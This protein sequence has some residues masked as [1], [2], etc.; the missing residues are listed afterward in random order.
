LGIGQPKLWESQALT[1]ALIGKLE[2][3]N[4]QLLDENEPCPGICI[5]GHKSRQ[6]GFTT[7]SRLMTD[8]RLFFWPYTR[9]MGASV[10]EA[11]V[12]DQ[13]YSRDKT[14]YNHLP[15]FL[16]PTL[17]FDVK[18]KQISFETGSYVMYQQANQESGL[19]QGSQF[20]V[21]HLTEV[22]SWPHPNIIELDFIPTIPQSPYALCLLESTAQG[23]GDWW[24]EFT[25]AVR[26]G[27]VYRWHYCFWPWYVISTKD[28]AKAPLDWTPSEAS[29]RHADLVRKT[30]AQFVG[31]TIELTRSQLYWYEMNYNNA[32]EKGELNLFLLNFAATPEASFQHSNIG[33]FDFELLNDLH[34]SSAATEFRRYDF[35]RL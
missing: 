35:E 24:H 26:K 8:H 7:E 10:D 25:E 31:K 29:L 33:A 17:K 30:S 21:S 5:A 32:K 18:N 12:N 34:E 28:R 14:C 20:D 19:G 13:L 9:A 11:K 1:L 15:W 16:K 22:A 3:E 2:E 4:F 27:K 23:R 6:L